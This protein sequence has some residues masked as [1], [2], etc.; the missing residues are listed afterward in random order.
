M[1][2]QRQDRIILLIEPDLLQAIDDFRYARRIPARS[3]AMRV[4]LQLGLEAARTDT[5]GA[6]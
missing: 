5:E 2:R 4:L 3:E 6:T 1:A